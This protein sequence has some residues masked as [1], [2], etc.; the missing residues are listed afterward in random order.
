ML[1]TKTNTKDQF[2]HQ[3]TSSKYDTLHS[4]FEKFEVFG[5]VVKH[6]HRVIVFHIFLQ[7]KLRRKLRKKLNVKSYAKKDL[8]DI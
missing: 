1:A 8:S 6:C 3:E 4:V 5:N 7:L 2:K